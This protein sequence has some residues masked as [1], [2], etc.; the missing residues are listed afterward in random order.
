MDI[1][2]PRRLPDEEADKTI[3]DHALCPCNGAS[4]P[5]RRTEASCL[6][7]ERE[8]FLVPAVG[9]ARAK[10]PEMMV[11]TKYEHMIL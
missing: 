8:Q 5:A 9:T 4:L 2:Q 7:A 11:A 3:A 10:K 1:H 6:L